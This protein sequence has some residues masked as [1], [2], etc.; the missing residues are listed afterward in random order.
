MTE[1]APAEFLML[2]KVAVIVISHDGWTRKPVD[3]GVLE[4]VL[5]DGEDRLRREDA[6][7]YKVVRDA[8]RSEA[9]DGLVRPTKELGLYGH[10]RERAL[11]DEK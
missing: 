4:A 2:Q 9:L 11:E 1:R 10:Q 8:R 5:V 6:L 3:E 7:A